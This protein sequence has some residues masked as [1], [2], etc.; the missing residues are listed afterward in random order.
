MTTDI[1]EINNFKILL[2]QS[3]SQKNIIEKCDTQQQLIGFTFYG[4][5][6]VQLGINYG[7]KTKTFSNTTGIATSFFANEEVQFVHNISYKKPLQSITIFSS[8]KDLQKIAGQESELST[9]YLHP[10]LHPQEDFV[11]GPN[12]VMTPDMRNA[13]QKIFNTS[14]TGATKKMFLES[15]ITELLA[16]FFGV[17]TDVEKTNGIKKQD[18]DKLYQAKE[19]LLKN[20]DTPPSLSE[21]SKQTG[22]NNYK[23]KKNFKTLFGVPVFKYLQNERLNK[24]HELLQNK[25]MSTQ[26]AAWFVG[27]ESISSF[28]NAFLKKFGHR[29]SEVK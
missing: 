20:L 24:A 6:N 10:L 1:I 16:H 8:V 22:L 28:S 26:E 19:I 21:L 2:E 9:K 5:G 11:A 29:P 27:Y 14:Y 25:N 3:I 15:Q 13:V 4:S 18:R 12:I 17:I 7:K 23:L